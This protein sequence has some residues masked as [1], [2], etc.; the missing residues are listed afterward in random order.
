MTP[1]RKKGTPK[2]GGRRRG[3][4]NKRT[5]ELLE[6]IESSGITPLDYM[7][8]TMRDPELPMELRFEAA[9]S[10][11]PYVHPKLAAVAHSSPGSG[12]QILEIRWRDCEE[13]KSVSAP[14]GRTAA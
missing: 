5:R 1:G 10:A 4:R 14:A 13:C 6:R 11:A 7:L 3:S 12:P 8:A 2:T 9:K